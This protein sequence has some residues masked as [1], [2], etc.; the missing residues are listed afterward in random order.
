M[1]MIMKNP[2]RNLLI[3]FLLL[4]IFVI[5]SLII[6]LSLNRPTSNSEK[7]DS[8][9]QPALIVDDIDPKNSND[10]PIEDTTVQPSNDDQIICADS[11]VVS[12]V[13]SLASSAK[14]YS[15]A[16]DAKAHLSPA[17]TYQPGQYYV[18]KCFDGM[19]NITRS[20]GVPG[21][22][23]DPADPYKNATIVAS[24]V[25]TPND[26]NL[27]NIMDLD[28]STVNWSHEYPAAFIRDFNGWWNIS[29][30]S[31]YLTFDCGYDYNNLVATILD[32]LKSKGVQAVFFVTGDFMED[33]PD[34][35]LRIVNEG[36]IVGNH[37][38]EHLNQP[39]NLAVSTDLVTADIRAWEEKYRSIVGSNPAV[40][41]FRPPAGAIS[42]RSL[43][44]MN[45]L[46]YKT[47]MWG[48]AYKDW[49]TTAQPTVD[50]AMVL[51]RQY[52]TAGDIILLHGVSATS[53]SI[54]GQYIDEYIAKGYNFLLP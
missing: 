46:G 4:I 52:T 34:L 43:A 25:P 13:F 35:V 11:V 38:Y 16:S 44:L 23:I 49:D 48:V 50:E 15:I 9:P 29:P 10:T 36:H 54:L 1:K 3:L 33:R 17:L 6:G 27:I 12:E 31:L 2:K 20:P 5:G 39:Q 37:S 18:F 22:W 8:K 42:R 30:A 41:Y 51:L 28:N 26:D 7:I 40:L 21:G 32:T 14:V 47:L 19:A 53:T 24:P 45:Q